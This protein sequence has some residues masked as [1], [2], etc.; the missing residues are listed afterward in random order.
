MNCGFEMK[1][2]KRFVASEAQRLSNEAWG[3]SQPGCQPA[4]P[5]KE[6]TV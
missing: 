3:S 5:L 4:V 1:P 2:N 6:L